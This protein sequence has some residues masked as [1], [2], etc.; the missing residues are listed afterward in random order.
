MPEKSLIERWREE[1]NQLGEQLKEKM[2]ELATV[3]ELPPLR[4]IT[5]EV[6][7]I[8]LAER[9][10]ELQGQLEIVM[11]YTSLMTRESVIAN[12]L[13]VR[14]LLTGHLASL[15]ENRELG[16]ETIIAA[17]LGAQA[18]GERETLRL[19]RLKR[20]DRIRKAKTSSELDAILE[21]IIEDAVA[22]RTGDNGATTNEP[23]EQPT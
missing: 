16:D 15:L 20:N 14:S 11:E 23:S 17:M 6:T 9:L 4:P 13:A 5:G 18:L 1:A 19:D 21:E 3:P 10:M 7:L 22:K 12:M 8:G 2:S